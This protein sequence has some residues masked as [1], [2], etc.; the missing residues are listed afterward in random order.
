MSD[1]ERRTEALRLAL[2]Y[3]KVRTERATAVGVMQ[4]PSS[5][6]AVQIAEEFEYYL[7]HGKPIY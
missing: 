3:V 5:K 2:T 1:D 4:P 6:E 7:K